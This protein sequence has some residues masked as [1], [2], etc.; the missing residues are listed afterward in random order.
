M[1]F[2]FPFWQECIY[3]DNKWRWYVR[4]VCW[5]DSVCFELHRFYARTII[6]HNILLVIISEL[7]TQSLIVNCLHQKRIEIS[8]S[9]HKITTNFDGTTTNGVYQW[10]HPDSALIQKTVWHVDSRKNTKCSNDPG[11]HVHI[12]CGSTNWKFRVNTTT[13]KVTK[14][15][16]LCNTDKP[17]GTVEKIWW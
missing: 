11:S 8:G 16:W 10:I 1:Y 4:N 7:D 13:S 15:W 6:D 9:G 5:G 14:E 12:S 2:S 3:K 17:L